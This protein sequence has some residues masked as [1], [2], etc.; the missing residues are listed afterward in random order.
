MMPALQQMDSI[1]LLLIT[2]QLFL[3]IG[4]TLPRAQRFEDLA[5]AIGLTVCGES[6]LAQQLESA[7]IGLQFLA[8]VKHVLAKNS[9]EPEFG[10]STSGG[11]RGGVGLR[12]VGK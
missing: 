5:F 6:L 4:A 8:E 1:E 3:L 12:R 7:D 11:E 2:A 9:S 10:A